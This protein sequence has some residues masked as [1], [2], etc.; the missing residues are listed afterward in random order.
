MQ[1]LH[2]MLYNIQQTYLDKIYTDD[3]PL[4]E[5][6]PSTEKVSIT[7]Y[8][9]FLL[10]VAFISIGCKKMLPYVGKFPPLGVST[11]GVLSVLIFNTDDIPL[12]ETRPSTEKFP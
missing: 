12:V 3:T 7:R 5:T 4:V 6:R 9:S 10:K 8:L 11:I 1:K 2:S